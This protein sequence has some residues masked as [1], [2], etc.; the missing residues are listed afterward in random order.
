MPYTMPKLTAF[1]ARRSSGGTPSWGSPNTWEA[2]TVWMSTP[3]LKP[4][5]MA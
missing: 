3:E 2:V 4:P 1:A 5:I